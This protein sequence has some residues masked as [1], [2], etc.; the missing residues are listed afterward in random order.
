[1]MLLHKQTAISIASLLLLSVSSAFAQ[2]AESGL[3]MTVAHLQP[4]RLMSMRLMTGVFDNPAMRNALRD[5]SL[6]DVEVGYLG[7]RNVSEYAQ[8]GEGWNGWNAE[9]MLLSA[10]RV[11]WWRGVELHMKRD[12]G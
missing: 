2:E 3:W 6:S 8:D 11:T 5:S 10:Y 12:S 1:M 7:N 4:Q 9:V